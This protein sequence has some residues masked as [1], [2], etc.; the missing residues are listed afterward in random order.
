MHF[1]ASWPYSISL[2]YH[3]Y[4]TAVRV[5]TWHGQHT[6]TQL[7]YFICN[8]TDLKLINANLSELKKIVKSRIR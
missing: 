5:K 1:R 3:L 7:H 2:L 8:C 6:R 4:L